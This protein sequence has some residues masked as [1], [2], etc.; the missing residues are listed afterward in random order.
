MF[1]LNELKRPLSR[2]TNRQF[3]GIFLILSSTDIEGYF[4]E[5]ID[6]VPETTFNPHEFKAQF[7]IFDQAENEKLIY[8]DNAATTQK[9]QAVIDRLTHFYLYENANAHRASHRLAR[10][11][12]D[13][14][15]NSRKII[16]GFINANDRD[17]VFCRGTTEGFNLLANGL[18]SQCHA[19][20]EIIITSAEHHANILPWRRLAE[21]RN[22]KIRLVP[23][24][25]G[26]PDL[27]QLASMLSD[28][29]RIVSF[30]MASNVLGCK[31]NL[32]SV[33]QLLKDHPCFYVIDAAQGLGHCPIDVDKLG[34]DF[35]VASAHKAYGPL[36]AGFV[37]GKQKVLSTLDPYLLGGE[38]VKSVTLDAAEFNK[39][40]GRF[41][42]GTM[43]LASIA[44]FGA[45]IEFLSQQDREGMHAHEVRLIQHIH[46]EL[47]SL[48]AIQLISKP[49]NNLGICTF[50]I[51]SDVIE[52]TSGDLAQWLDEHDIAVR[53][54]YHCAQPL[55]ESRALQ[56]GLR[57]SVAGYNT[58][59][60]CDKVVRVIREWIDNIEES[61]TTTTPCSN[62]I[63][64]SLQN[65]K[66]WQARYKM[67]MEFGQEE[68]DESIQ[69]DDNIIHGCE[70]KTWLAG[71]QVDGKYQFITDSESRIIRGL[72]V[73]M[74]HWFNGKDADFIQNFDWE[75]ECQKLG[76]TRHL[77]ASR[78]NGFRAMI[79]TAQCSV[80][81]TSS[82]SE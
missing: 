9:P 74:K 71:S 56:Q 25:D 23:D 12:T 62:S 16:A 13:A 22:M 61:K 58:F 75:T 65:A 38:M 29:T 4:T 80:V 35:L 20:E 18:A 69:A 36:G 67:L 27:S 51:K 21:Q 17:I 42:A 34:C 1:L 39:A 3:Y 82:D 64:E 41:E 28:N 57:I 8:V 70:A 49:E 78:N 81:P 54:G 6:L 10:A 52:A 72:G 79:L 68:R 11:A 19:Q 48:P 31:L 60:D 46:K 37:Y 7:P 14:I 15:E 26:I 33:A 77:S 30:T 73:L 44:G 47:S 45:A 40:P 66:N 59:E 63:L 5:R 53:V 55:Y 32:E 50:N 24:I 43:Q 2:Q 76:L